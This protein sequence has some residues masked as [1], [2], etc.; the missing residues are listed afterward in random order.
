MAR[1]SHGLANDLVTARAALTPK[2][3]VDI[4]RISQLQFISNVAPESFQGYL[5]QTTFFIYR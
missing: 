5:A 4:P 3:L 2:E 1:M